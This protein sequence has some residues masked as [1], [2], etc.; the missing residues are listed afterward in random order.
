MCNHQIL[1][2][3]IIINFYYYHNKLIVI[4]IS[5][6]V[7]NSANLLVWDSIMPKMKKTYDDIRKQVESYMK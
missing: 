7:V 2:D 1:Y 3:I 4:N 5:D 6:A